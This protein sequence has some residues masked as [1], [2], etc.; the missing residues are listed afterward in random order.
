MRTIAAGW[1]YLDGEDPRNWGA[2]CVVYS[3]AQLL[4]AFALD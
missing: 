1:G 4:P 3:P 2:D